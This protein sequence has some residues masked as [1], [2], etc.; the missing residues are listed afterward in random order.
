M[1]SLDYIHHQVIH[2]PIALL[3]ISLLFDLLG[4]YLKNDKLFFS[5]WYTLLTGAGVSIVAVATGF[6]A[7]VNY[8]HMSEPLPIFETHGSTQILAA[9]CFISYVYGATYKTKLTP[10][11]R[12]GTLLWGLVLSVFCFMEAI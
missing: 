10:N 6:I 9:I 2:F 5:S 8:G 7:D 3:S 4:Y 1:F 12:G 11:R